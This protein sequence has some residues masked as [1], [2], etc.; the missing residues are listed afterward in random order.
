MTTVLRNGVGII[1][2]KGD[3]HVV[4][5][6]ANHEFLTTFEEKLRA[7]TAQP[8]DMSMAAGKTLQLVTSVTFGAPDLR[9]VYIGTL[10]MNSLPTFR[11]PIAGLPMRH[12]Q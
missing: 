3:Y 9:T 11:S 5:E 8:V 12:W 2:P 4:F 7:R 10:G 6:D 1:T